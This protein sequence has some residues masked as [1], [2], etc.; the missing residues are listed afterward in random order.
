MLVSV[1]VSA[2]GST[3]ESGGTEASTGA[4]VGSEPTHAPA[5]KVPSVPSTSEKAIRFKTIPP[6]KEPPTERQ[7]SQVSSLH[8]AH[9]ER[10][11][12]RVSRPRVVEK[13]SL[14]RLDETAS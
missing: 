6:E 7:S 10:T 4:E 8:G 3:A 11:N 13:G 9:L 14:A 12:R 1:P 2:P 5:A